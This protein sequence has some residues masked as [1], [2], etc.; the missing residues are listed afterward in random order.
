[1]TAVTLKR[2]YAAASRFSLLADTGLLLPITDYD[3]IILAFSGGKDSLAAG[4]LLLDMGVPRHK[5]EW[6]H[7]RI[8]GDRPGLFDWPCTESYCEAVA[9]ALG[10]TVRY[11]W[12]DG[13]FE[14]ELHR[15][16]AMT[17]GVYYQDGN[18]VTQ[19]LPPAKPGTY[20]PD[21]RRMYDGD[22]PSCVDCGTQRDGYGTRMKYPQRTSNLQT[23]WCSAYIK[24]DVCKRTICN[25][26]R[27]A[28]GNILMITGE[29]RQE[30]TAR[31]GYDEALPHLSTNRKRRVDQW[32]AVIDWTE[33]DVWAIIRKHRIVPHPAYRLGF[34]RVS[35]M[36][37]I[38]GD[39]DQWAT[40]RQ[41][42]PR[43]FKRHAANERRFGLTIK[44]NMSVVQQ[45]DKGTSFAA[46]APPWLVDLAMSTAYPLSEALVPKTGTWEL[47]A[48]A[49][50]RCGGPT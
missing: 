2:E 32:R 50:K 14:G 6:W 40:V 28:S 19:Y 17:K 21:C 44:Q 34:G 30:S 39:Y 37:C 5:I 10:I 36:F 45:A 11:Q 25:D 13:G 46:D 26:P 16:D 49:Y 12:K 47:P 27:F 8:D 29:R 3:K 15:Q 43:R 41:L 20:C 31:S 18:G 9:H 35:C 33:E 38:F 42:D 48:G 23:R 4:L 22:E 7:Q 1:M 24:I